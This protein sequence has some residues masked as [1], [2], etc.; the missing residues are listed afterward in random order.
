MA[1]PSRLKALNS[2]DDYMAKTSICALWVAIQA[3]DYPQYY[4]SQMLY[5]WGISLQE[6]ALFIHNPGMEI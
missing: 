1:H 6:L 3:I 2:L 5:S 4:V